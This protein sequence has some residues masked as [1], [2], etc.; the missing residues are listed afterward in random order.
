MSKFVPRTTNPVA[1]T[2]ANLYATFEQ[3]LENISRFEY[4]SD[5][6][7]KADP[8]SSQFILVERYNKG[9]LKDKFRIEKSAIEYADQDRLALYHVVA[10]VLNHFPKA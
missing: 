8:L 9:L 5:F 7:I 10:V 4:Q 6:R 2:L 1:R 3:C